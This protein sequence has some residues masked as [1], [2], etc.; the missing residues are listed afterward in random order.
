MTHSRDFKAADSYAMSHNNLGPASFL[1]NGLSGK[2]L[3]LQLTNFSL[4]VK[5]ADL[6]STKALAP[7]RIYNSPERAHPD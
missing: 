1:W 7:R 5:C 6:A 3:K 2:D 4:S